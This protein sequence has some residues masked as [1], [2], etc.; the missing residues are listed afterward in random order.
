M[1]DTAHRLTRAVE[2]NTSLDFV[3]LEENER[4]GLIAISV[5]VSE[6]LERLAFLALRDEPPWG[7]RCPEDKE[8]L[9]DG[10]ETLENRGNSPCPV[11][12]DKL[13][14]EGGP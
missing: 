9:E 5:I 13:S 1:L 14:T 7:F 12:V 11:V 6:S 10:W 4:V 3:E 2:L 8:E